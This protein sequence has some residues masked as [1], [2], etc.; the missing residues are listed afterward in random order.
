MLV[1]VQVPVLELGFAFGIVASNFGGVL[2]YLLSISPFSNLAFS[3]SFFGSL[4]FCM[5]LIPENGVSLPKACFGFPNWVI[6]LL[7]TFGEKMKLKRI[8]IE[9]DIAA[10]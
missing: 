9:I 7:F 1:Q 8:Q 5:N 6:S 2:L 4:K 10:W 3:L